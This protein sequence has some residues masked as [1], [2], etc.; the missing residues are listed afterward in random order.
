MRERL[1]RRRVLEA[2]LDL[3][4]REGADALTMRRLGAE[5]GVAA[6]SI[7]N[8]VPGREALLDGLSE[9]LVGRIGAAPAAGPRELVERFMHG[10][11]AV[12][13][14]HPDAFRLVGMRPLH[15]L[16]ALRP[17]EAVLGALRELGLG[18][19]EATHAYRALLSYARGFALAEI[20]GFTLELPVGAGRA[21][22][23]PRDVPAETFPHIAELA[24]E[25]AAPDH[26]A[27]FAFGANLLLA[28][29]PDG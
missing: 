3:L 28:A 29:L 19:E 14:A 6:M 1:T 25:L 16:D 26:D 13:L 4:D 5:L 10:I 18:A 7:Y 9:V 23:D 20:E 24:S 21:T 15:T 22:V 17:V 27:A 8:H 2:A 11:R 12:A